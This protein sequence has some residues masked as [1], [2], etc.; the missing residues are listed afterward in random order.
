MISSGR[1]RSHKNG[2]AAMVLLLSPVL[3]AAEAY[4]G[5]S[6]S[7]MSDAEC[8]LLKRCG[9][10]L[11]KS[12]NPALIEVALRSSLEFDPTGFFNVNDARRRNK[13]ID[14][15]WAKFACSKEPEIQA[16]CV[17]HVPAMKSSEKEKDYP[18][19]SD[20][21]EIPEVHVIPAADGKAKRYTQFI[22]VFR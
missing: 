1:R 11:W 4:N 8:E 14:R 2:V 18:N 7:R 3:S 16:L 9:E 20:G 12:E 21:G 13:A 5:F 19:L 6:S 15:I 10:E 17:Y 22:N